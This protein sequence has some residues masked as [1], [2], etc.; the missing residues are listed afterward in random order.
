VCK[1]AVRVRTTYVNSRF[2]ISIMLT[3]PAKQDRKSTSGL[4]GLL[5][6]EKISSKFRAQRNCSTNRT[7]V[8]RHP[9]DNRPHFDTFTRTVYSN[10]ISSWSLCWSRD[11]MDRGSLFHSSVTD[12]NINHWPGCISTLHA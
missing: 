3:L 9:S 1:Y 4:Q 6:D 7:L 5:C 10:Y 8:S 2:Y 11:L 12:N